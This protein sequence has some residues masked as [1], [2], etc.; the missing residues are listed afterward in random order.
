MRVEVQDSEGFLVPTAK[1]KI[2][3]AVTGA[4]KL[5]GVANGNPSDLTPDKSHSRE[6]FGGLG[7]VLVQ[8][9]VGVAGKLE[10]RVSAAGLLGDVA[11]LDV[12]LPAA[13]R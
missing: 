6:A 10:V 2:S 12:Q 8:T 4:G 9:V 13:A 11:V 1:N 3:Y 7:R 5:H